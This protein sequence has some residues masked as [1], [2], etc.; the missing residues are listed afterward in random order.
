M[1]IVRVASLRSSLFRGSSVSVTKTSWLVWH[2]HRKR[3]MMGPVTT[4][5]HPHSS[6]RGQTAA[7]D[8]VRDRVRSLETEGRSVAV[9]NRSVVVAIGGSVA[10]GKSTFAQKL[11]EALTEPFEAADRCRRHSLPRAAV[12]V[13]TDGFLHPNN[14]LEPR[15]LTYRKGLPETYDAEAIVSFIEAC[16]RGEQTVRIPRYSHQSFD[17]DGSET[18][19]IAPVVLLEGIN[20]LQLPYAPFVDL[21][22]YLDTDSETIAQWYVRRFLT[23]IDAA[24]ADP[25]SFYA[26]FVLFSPSKRAETAREV[27]DTINFPNLENHIAPSRVNADIIVSLDEHHNVRR[28]EDVRASATYLF[29]PNPQ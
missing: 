19:E 20:T 6:D 7:M 23:F 25:S 2:L 3:N 21:R 29:D 18:I 5:D 11:A 26:R 24:E 22:I 17:I 4:P 9:E 15:G 12:V 1:P 13:G 8:W 10:V 14:I 16:H 27:W 28:I